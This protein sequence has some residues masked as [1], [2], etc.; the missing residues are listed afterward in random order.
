MYKTKEIARKGR[1]GPGPLLSTF[2]LAI[3]EGYSALLQKPTGR[4]SDRWFTCLP[5]IY[6]TILLERTYDMNE[7]TNTAYIVQ[8][9]LPL[10]LD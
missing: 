2:G 8:S 1:M 9:S 6:I 4:Y 7:R 3:Y 10:S 5:H